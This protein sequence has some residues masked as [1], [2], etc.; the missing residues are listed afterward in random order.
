[1]PEFG[2]LGTQTSWE[3]MRSSCSGG[4]GGYND[5][6]TSTFPT[7]GPEKCPSPSQPQDFPVPDGFGEQLSNMLTIFPVMLVPQMV[8]SLDPSS[9]TFFFAN[10]KP[11][12]WFG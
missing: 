2:T 7:H 10:L 1:M 3:G 8:V 9:V 11:G 4:R 12:E 5:T 6:S